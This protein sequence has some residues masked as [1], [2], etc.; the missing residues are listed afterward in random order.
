MMAEVVKAFFDQKSPTSFVNASDILADVIEAYDEALDVV[1]QHAKQ[2]M[3]NDLEQW[4]LHEEAITRLVDEADDSESD[5]SSVVV[6]PSEQPKTPPSAPK[7]KPAERK[8]TSPVSKDD[9]KALQKRVKE[10][11]REA[12]AA[13][14]QAEKAARRVKKTES[15]DSEQ[16][17]KKRRRRA[18]PTPSD[19]DQLVASAM[20]DLR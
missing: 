20:P 1:A 18:T 13:K 16:E 10:M 11:E 7:K 5:P 15:A 12:K 8:K 17:P 3:E 9:I 2:L 14:R 6:P 19:V 4:K